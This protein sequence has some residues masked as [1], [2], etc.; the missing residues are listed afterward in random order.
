MSKLNKIWYKEYSRRMWKRHWTHWSS[1]MARLLS[2][3]HLPGAAASWAVLCP[4]AYQRRIVVSSII[5]VLAIV[6]R[7]SLIRSM[8]LWSRRQTLSN[9][10]ARCFGPDH[11]HGRHRPRQGQ[12][13]MA[14][15]DDTK[16]SIGTVGVL[17]ALRYDGP[18]CNNK[19][20]DNK[21]SKYRERYS[22]S[23]VET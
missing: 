13:N 5:V 15:S 2:L 3:L 11:R 7:R 21:R 9:L 23:M 20:A 19:Q 1:P 17:T 8:R 10:G 6:A 16:S 22:C 14:R 12:K 4:A 18:R